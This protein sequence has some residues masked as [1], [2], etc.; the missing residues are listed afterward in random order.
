MTPNTFLI[1]PKA[2]LVDTSFTG[3]LSQVMVCIVLFLEQKFQKQR[4]FRAL[5]LWSFVSLYSNLRIYRLKVSCVTDRLNYKQ[6]L[7]YFIVLSSLV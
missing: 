2:K 4:P 5:K 6:G 7:L 3:A 1:S